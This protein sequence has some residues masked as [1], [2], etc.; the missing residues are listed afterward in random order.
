MNG[1][2]RI[3]GEK[4]HPCLSVTS[5]FIRG[6]FTTLEARGYNPVNSSIS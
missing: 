1:F 6:V 3:E 5:V 2:A 4:S